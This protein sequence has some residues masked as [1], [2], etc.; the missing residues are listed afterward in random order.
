VLVVAAVLRS[1][2]ELREI[3]DEDDDEETGKPKP[4]LVKEDALGVAT[5]ELKGAKINKV[6]G[7]G[8]RVPRQS[9]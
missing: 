6:A 8:S 1:V 7:R 3:Y 2:G 4:D 5:K 9:A